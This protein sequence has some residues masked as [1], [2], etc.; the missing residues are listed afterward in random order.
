M[1]DNLTPKKEDNLNEEG[2][3][4]KKTD[5]SFG[6][7]GNVP[8][9]LSP[10]P[11]PS[12]SGAEE[13]KSSISQSVKQAS[14]EDFDKRMEKLETKGKKR[15][16]RFS[17]IG[18]ITAA[19]IGLLMM[20]AGYY[21]LTDVIGITEKAQESV[22][23]IPNIGRE[24]GNGD[25]KTK[26]ELPV[27]RPEMMACEI[28]SDCIE[29]QADCCNCSRGGIQVG[30]NN[31]FYE[32]WEKELSEKCVKAECSEIDLCL[33]GKLYCDEM[34]CKFVVEPKECK[35][36][37]T[38]FAET[39]ESPAVCCRDLKKNF[40][41]TEFVN[42]ECLEISEEAIC[43]NCGDGICGDGENICNCPEDCQGENNQTGNATSSEEIIEPGTG[44]CPD[45]VCPSGDTLDTDGDGLFD[46]EEI[47]I[48]SDINNPDTDGDG[49][50]DGEEI[51]YGTDV[52][53]PDTDGD[54]YLD[55]D[56]VRS[57]Y[58]PLGEGML[59]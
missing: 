10:N 3:V 24:N 38:V 13:A 5:S 46:W 9:N 50:L 33:S 25:K 43:I 49:L 23:N 47:I 12:L 41:R 57:G 18:L 39:L 19:V 42:G 51:I 40:P 16:I 8:A 45:G 21:L 6:T 1:F 54:G 30:I 44:E 48:G 34:L 32:D 27:I 11:S 37:G 53:N 35:S 15:G 55:G 20:G 7:Y 17:R 4:E 31:N 59:N 26:T 52:L 22:G 58:N 14:S 56:E 29:T 36:E 2:Q 28:D